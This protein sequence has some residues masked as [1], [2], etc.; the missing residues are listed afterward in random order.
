LPGGIGAPHHAN[1]LDED[2]VRA[3]DFARAN[4]AGLNAHSNV[5][6]FRTQVVAGTMY[7]FTFEGHQGEVKV[8]SKPWENF[9][10]I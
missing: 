6:S 5:V 3:R 1:D 2:A 10:A 8:W 4:V 9:L 7:Y